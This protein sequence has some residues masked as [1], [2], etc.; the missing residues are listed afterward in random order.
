[1]E[2]VL[3]DGVGNGALVEV[4]AHATVV[5]AMGV[6]FVR[7]Q[8]ATIEVEGAAL[9]LFRVTGGGTPRVR[10]VRSFPKSEALHAE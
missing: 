9:P 6:V 7:M 8:E 10:K 4:P 1:M 5:R 2:A 3:V